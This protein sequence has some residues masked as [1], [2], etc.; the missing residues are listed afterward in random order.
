MD[1]SQENKS[2]ASL[3]ARFDKDLYLPET[4]LEL[5]EPAKAVRQEYRDCSQWKRLRCRGVSVYAER[6]RGTVFVVQVGNSVEFDWTWEGAVAFRPKSIDDFGALSDFA[7][8]L[9][10]IHI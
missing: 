2:E 3:V 6:D 8:E 5:T 1:D 10:L 4:P 9:S 7:L